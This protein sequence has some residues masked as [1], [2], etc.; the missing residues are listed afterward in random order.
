MKLTKLVAM[1]ALTITPVLE[2]Y[3]NNGFSFDESKS[4]CGIEDNR[5]P[6]FEPEVGRT[7]QRGAVGGCTV[8]MIGRSCAITAGHCLD[9]LQEVHF[10][11]GPTFTRRS[12]QNG[13]DQLFL[14]LPGL[15]DVYHVMDERIFGEYSGIGMDWAVIAIDKNAYTQ[16]YPGDLQGYYEVDFN[17]LPEVGDMLRITGYGVVNDN[18]ELT[19]SQ[20][21]DA[22]VTFG[23]DKEKAILYHQVDT[24][25]G[26]SGSAVIDERTGKIVGI[27]THAGCMRVPMI[28]RDADGEVIGITYGAN[29]STLLYQNR[30]VES[31][32]KSCL[33]WEAANL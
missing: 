33:R 9:S 21:T 24:T 17:T 22:G 28:I 30:A 13:E 19:V 3:A 26:N 31:A 20:Q 14:S 7:Q 16:Q 2:A 12:T 1:T 4:I 10:N 29:R 25:G 18:R 15:H 23:V 32:V 6:S 11:T 5:T 27:H 8:T